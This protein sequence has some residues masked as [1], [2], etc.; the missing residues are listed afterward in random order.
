MKELF[1]EVKPALLKK[2]LASG[3]EKGKLV[4]TGQR[5]GVAGTV[6]V[7]PQEAT[8][9]KQVLREGTADGKVAVDGDSV[10]MAYK[11]TLEDGSC[12]DK[13]AHFKFTLGI[14]EVIK[15]WDLAVAGMREGERARFTIPSKLGYGKRGSPPEIPP[16]AT[17]I[18][19]VTLNKV[20]SR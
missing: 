15:G 17:L 8:V 7:T 13:S 5:F 12:F 9:A 10:D 4:Q 19:E 11:G 2:A 3:V 6:L 18:F 20:V 14:G 1:G 16:D